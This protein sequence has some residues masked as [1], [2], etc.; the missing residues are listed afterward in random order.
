MVKMRERLEEM[1][2][3]ACETMRTAQQHQKK[4]YDQKARKR[5]FPPGQKVQ[6]LLPISYSKLLT[7]WHGPYEVTRWVGKVSYELYIQ[8]RFKKYQF[9]HINLVHQEPVHHNMF[10][11]LVQEE[12]VTE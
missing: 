6:L 12:E 9:F 8:L 10:V 4:W 3:L 11:C 1:S 7:K 5:V 2:E